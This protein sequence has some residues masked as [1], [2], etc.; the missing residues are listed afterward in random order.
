MI[1]LGI[2]RWGH[3]PRLPEWAK[4][5]YRREAEGNLTS[6][7][8]MTMQEAGVMGE[9]AGAKECRQPPEAGKAREPIHL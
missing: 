6:Q 2:F 9:R 4:G 7:G 5:P 3:Y 8:V 1:R